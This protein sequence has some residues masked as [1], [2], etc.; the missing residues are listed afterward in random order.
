M[1]LVSVGRLGSC[2]D[3]LELLE[4][5]LELDDFPLWCEELCDEETLLPFLPFSFEL[6]LLLRIL[7]G[8][9]SK[10]SCLEELPPEDWCSLSDLLESLELIEPRAVNS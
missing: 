2:I 10:S 6:E 4:V 1:L 5:L 7:S 8:V 9:L 3:N